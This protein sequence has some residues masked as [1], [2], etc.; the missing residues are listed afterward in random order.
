[1]YQ[2]VL[3]NVRAIDHLFPTH[4]RWYLKRTMQDPATILS[5]TGPIMSGQPD[6]C[7][8]EHKRQMRCCTISYDSSVE[9]HTTGLLALFRKAIPISAE[10]KWLQNRGIGMALQGSKKGLRRLQVPAG[11]RLRQQ[12]L[13]R[14]PS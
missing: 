2:Y 10:S 8:A 7:I 14:K 12:W 13:H 1:M 5:L 3:S 11:A 6:T 4:N 9:C